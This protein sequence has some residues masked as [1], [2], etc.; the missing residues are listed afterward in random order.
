MPSVPVLAE[1]T[2]K[3]VSPNLISDAAAAA[4]CEWGEPYA[5]RCYESLDAIPADA[6]RLIAYPAQ[7]DLFLSSQWFCCLAEHGFSPDLKP[8]I[9]VANDARGAPACFLFCAARERDRT[10]QGLSNFYTTNF[11]A[12]FANGQ[13]SDPRL[14]NRIAQHV[15]KEQPRWHRILLTFLRADRFTTDFLAGSFADEGFIINRFFQYENWYCNTNGSSFDRYYGLRPSRTKNTIKRNENKLRQKKDVIIQI[16]LDVSDRL[17]EDWNK[18]Y[19]NSWKAKESFPEFVPNFMRLCAQLGVLR[20]GTLLINGEPAAAQFWIISG[21]RATI[22]KL[23]HDKKYAKWS[24]GSILTRDMMRYALDRDG[25]IE[26]DYG[27][28][29]ESYKRDWMNVSR[30]IIGIEAFNGGTILGS[31]LALKWRLIEIAKRL[32]HPFCKYPEPPFK[33]NR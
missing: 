4:F 9:Y 8:R 29:S 3:S 30:E 13:L 5:I 2:P 31:W 12:T 15:A 18:I 28:G 16:D 11:A 6:L 19:A 24:V 20:L 17:I 10:L 32:L 22:Y 23:A 21:Q 27:V 14:L 33:L 25:V 7:G 1:T 26:V